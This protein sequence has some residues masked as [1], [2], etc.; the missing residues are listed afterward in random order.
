MLVDTHA[1]LQWPSFET[2]RTEVIERAKSKDV[3]FIVNVGYD[4]AACE[5]AISIAKQHEGVFAAVGIHPHNAESLTERTLSALVD[6]AK[7]DKVVAIGEIGLDFYRNLSPKGQQ[8]KAFE[9]QLALAEDLSLPVVIHQRSAERETFDILRKFTGKRVLIHCWSGSLNMALRHV[10]LGHTISLAG[11]VTFP[12]ARRLREVA[13][14]VPLENV[15]LETDAPWLAPQR[16][17]GQRNE[18]ALIVEI[19]DALAELKGVDR[20]RIAEATTDNARSF[21]SI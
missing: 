6:L 16:H 15:V 1:H 3:R 13:K 9:E 7:Q 12:N 17:R 5:Q 4:L 10:Q 2:D 11:P 21:F 8:V 18:P 20:Q 19:A 14:T